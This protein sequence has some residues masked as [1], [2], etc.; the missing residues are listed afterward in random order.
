MKKAEI[1]PVFKK[2]ANTS[3][4]NYRPITTLSNMKNK[5]SK[6]L[7]GLRKSHNTQHSLQSH[8]NSILT[9]LKAQG[10]GNNSVELFR[11]FSSNK[12]QHCK[13]NN[14]FSQLKIVSAGIPQ[15]FFW[16]HYF[17]NFFMN[18]LFLFL[19]KYEPANHADE[20]ILI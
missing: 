8:Y 16:D 1:N 17:F 9:K 20:S 5:L 14:S 11:S 15:G 4:D 6:Y 13:I 10:L 2:C 18:D 7:T 12:Y 3:K 19:Q